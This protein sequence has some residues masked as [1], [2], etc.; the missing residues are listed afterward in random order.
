MTALEQVI[1]NLNFRRSLFKQD[2]Y[3]IDNLSETDKTELLDWIDGCLSP[4]NISAD[5]ERSA[6]EQKRLR[7]MYEKAAK[8][9]GCDDIYNYWTNS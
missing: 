6:T 7:I 4:E 9:L 8:Q 2:E 5:G 3:D 1:D